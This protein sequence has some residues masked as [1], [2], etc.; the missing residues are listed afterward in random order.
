MNLH[1]PAL[2]ARVVLQQPSRRLEGIA[3]HNVEVLVL[4]IC[5]KM[6]LPF[7]LVAALDGAVQTHLVPND[8]LPLARPVQCGRET[9]LRTC[10]GGAGSR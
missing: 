1:L 3:D 5:F 9:V 8:D 6:L 2:P 4:W 7:F 10:D